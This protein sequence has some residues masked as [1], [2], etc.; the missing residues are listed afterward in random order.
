M[1]EKKVLLFNAIEARELKEYLE[2]LQW[3]LKHI[4]ET[5]SDVVYEMLQVSIPNKEMSD[6][7][8][9]QRKRVHGIEFMTDSLKREVDVLFGLGLED[10]PFCNLSNFE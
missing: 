10:A 1:N 3:K 6:W 2:G 7:L 5:A 9:V 8:D 4:S